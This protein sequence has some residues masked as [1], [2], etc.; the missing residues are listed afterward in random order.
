MHFSERGPIVEQCIIAT[1]TGQSNEDRSLYIR[2]CSKETAK[3]ATP[4]GERFL[5]EVRGG[6]TQSHLIFPEQRERETD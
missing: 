4:L 6:N 2:G 1:G 3:I 5:L